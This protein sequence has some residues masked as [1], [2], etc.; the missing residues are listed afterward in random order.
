[1]NLKS[2]VNSDAYNKAVSS[3]MAEA[4]EKALHLALP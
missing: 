4:H 1:M 2:E 3:V